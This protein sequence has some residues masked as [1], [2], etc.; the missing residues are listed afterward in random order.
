MRRKIKKVWEKF[1]GSKDTLYLCTVKRKER[2]TPD[3][4][5]KGGERPPGSGN[6][7]MTERSMTQHKTN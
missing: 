1:G 4:S 5:R 6:D 2:P 3:P 7:L